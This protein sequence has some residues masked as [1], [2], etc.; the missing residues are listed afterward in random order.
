M[1]KYPFD[2]FPRNCS[3]F[4]GNLDKGYSCRGKVKYGVTCPDHA[5]TGLSNAKRLKALQRVARALSPLLFNPGT[6]FI[7]YRSGY[8]TSEMVGRQLEGELYAALAACD[9]RDLK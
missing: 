5:V 6:K 8:S 3:D 1:S 9:A 2:D 4:T 7:H